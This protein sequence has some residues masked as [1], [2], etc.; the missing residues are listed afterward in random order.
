[1]VNRRENTAEFV[2]KHISDLKNKYDFIIID[3]NPS[4]STLNVSIS[5]ASDLILMP[6]NPDGYSVDGLKRT[7][8]ELD[9]I[10]ASYK[11][12]TSFKLLFCRFDQREVT[13]NKYLGEYVSL[14]KEQMLGSII[15]RTADISTAVMNNS[16]VFQMKNSIA[17][18]DY[19]LLAKEILGL[20]D[21]NKKQIEVR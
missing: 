16:T 2:N 10:K 11:T 5:C 19:D 6:V 3:C 1:M 21:F 15:R 7:V 17:K 4:L 20:I 18:I 12:N 14:Y 13:S 8:E 9:R